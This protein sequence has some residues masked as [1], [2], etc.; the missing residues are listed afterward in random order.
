MTTSKTLRLKKPLSSGQQA[1]LSQIFNPPTVQTQSKDGANQEK[2]VEKKQLTPAERAAIKI[3]EAS[4]RK[5]LMKKRLLEAVNWLITTYP[6]CFNR[7]APKP[8]K[9]GILNDI[10]SEGYWQYSKGFLRKTLGFYTGS[11]LYQNSILE[12]NNRY[13]LSGEEVGEITD[14]DREAVVTRIKLLNERKK[15][16]S[17]TTFS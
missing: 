14:E 3:S 8:L 5:Y 16:K 15:D 9:I 12:N 6:N 13:S 10:I 4:A 17:N 7:A 1:R 11:A 2:Q